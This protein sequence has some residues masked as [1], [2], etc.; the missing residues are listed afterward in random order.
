MRTALL[1][2]LALG[3]ATPLAAQTSGQAQKPAPAAPKPAP[4]APATPA[5]P[6]T[7]R[8]AAT[9]ERSGITMTVTDQHGATLSG[10]HVEMTGPIERTG[11]TDASGHLNFPGLQG[12]TYLLRFSGDSIVTFEREVTLR[13]G[14]IE[15]LDIKLSPAPP[16]RET[17]AAAPPA[18]TAGPVGAPQIGSLT[19]LADKESK[20]K[21]P[22]QE[23]LLSCSGLTRN[24]LVILTGEQPE[25]LYKAAESTYYVLSG[26]GG[27]H[28]GALQSVIGPGSFVSV[29]RGTAYSIARQGN[30][31][32]VM[33]WS[34]SGEPCETAR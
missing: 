23:T 30:R 11:D 7:P 34:L 8:R 9:S 32:L 26:Q 20:S 18:P 14:A 4:A 6:R 16:P 33:L 1:L 27:A 5:R 13:A 12:G 17:P 24:E 25:R 21:Q 15:H 2:S 28:V 29:P 19:N 3:L 10:I 22:Q 31:P